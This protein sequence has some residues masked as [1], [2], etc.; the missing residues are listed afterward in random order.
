MLIVYYVTLL[1]GWGP[2]T[3]MWVWLREGCMWKEK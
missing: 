2:V 1:G 3:I